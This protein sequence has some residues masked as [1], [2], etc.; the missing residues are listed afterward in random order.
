MSSE[1][2]HEQSIAGSVFALPAAIV[3]PC[4]KVLA[5]NGITPKRRLVTIEEYTL[6]AF[7]FRGATNDEAS[8]LLVTATVIL[9]VNAFSSC[10]KARIG[11][12]VGQYFCGVQGDVRLLPTPKEAS[13]RGD[14]GEDGED[15]DERVAEIPED[16]ET[17]YQGRVRLMLERVSRLTGGLSFTLH[18]EIRGHGYP[19]LPD[20]PGHINLYFWTAP[21]GDSDDYFLARAFKIPLCKESKSVLTYRGVPGRGEFVGDGKHDLVQLIGNNWYVLTSVFEFAH[22]FGTEALVSKLL[23]ISLARW[24]ALRKGARPKHREVMIGRAQFV[25]TTTRWVNSLPDALKGEVQKQRKELERLRRE[26]ERIMRV[27]QDA[28]RALKAMDDGTTTRTLLESLPQQWEAIRKN[29]HVADISQVG[30]GLHITTVPIVIDYDGHR[31]RLGR[32]VIRLNKDG[33]LTLWNLELLHPK[34][35]PHPHIDDIGHPCYGNASAAIESAL[36]EHRYADAVQYVTRWLVD[37]YEPSLAQHLIIDWP[38]Q[39]LESVNA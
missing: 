14:D 23:A 11:R 6:D 24:Q 31:Y 38:V 7:E 22:R 34:G 30:E 3:E 25:K 28:L 37:G 39:Q 35:I 5:D 26:R 21:P 17:Y 27:Y 19:P 32:F 36:A 12:T 20:T 8:Q 16:A 18:P 1:T 9:G 29:P 15:E 13:E 2:T 4:L 10:E 33:V